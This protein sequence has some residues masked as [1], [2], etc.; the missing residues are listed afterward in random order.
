[1]ADRT[2]NRLTG[3]RN[4]DACRAWYPVI[5]QS[6]AEDTMSRWIPKAAGLLVAMFAAGCTN[7]GHTEQIPLHDIRYYYVDM[8]AAYDRDMRI[9]SDGKIVVAERTG[10]T[11]TDARQVTGQ[12]SPEQRAALAAAFE[13]WKDLK[14]SYALDINSVVQIEYDGYQV[15]T[16]NLGRTPYNFTTV[17][18]LLD[19]IARTTLAAAA[20]PA[21]QPVTQP[22]ATRP[23]KP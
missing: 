9:S 7:T 19:K 20:Q 17:K 1:M 3:F 21:T 11:R 14:P 10:N 22:D 2:G 18:E 15:Q 12:I 6:F 23:S 4:H 8:F 13:G 5:G 16:S